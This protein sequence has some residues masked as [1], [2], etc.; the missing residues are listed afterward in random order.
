MRTSRL[1][2]PLVLASG[3]AV[4]ALALAR[5]EA[6]LSLALVIPVIVATGPWGGLGIALVVFGLV[7]TFLLGIS[8]DRPGTV[9]SPVDTPMPGESSTR[10]RWGGV[11]LVGPL[12][13]VFGS[14]AR[15]SREMLLLAAIL[16][17]VLTVLTVLV[18]LAI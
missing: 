7:A 8:P 16:L 13:I 4:V 6:S 14:D 12:P 1:L 11:V 5:G 2:G 18:F 10:R 17:L 3:V 9:G 15:V